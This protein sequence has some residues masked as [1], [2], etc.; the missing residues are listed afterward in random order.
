[1]LGKHLNLLPK[2]YFQT[3]GGSFGAF[4]VSQLVFHFDKQVFGL[5][6]LFTVAGIPKDA[7][8]VFENL[9]S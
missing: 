9:N 4:D 6:F 2:I 1:L 8:Y 3:D 7:S 5:L